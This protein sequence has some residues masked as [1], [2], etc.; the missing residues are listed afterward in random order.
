MLQA[1]TPNPYKCKEGTDQTTI[2][3]AAEVSGETPSTSSNDLSA[4]NAVN[5]NQIKGFIQ[6]ECLDTIGANKF[7]FSTVFGRA[8]RDADLKDQEIRK[9]VFDDLF[10]SRFNA[11]MQ[12]KITDLIEKFDRRVK[13]MCQDTIVSCAMTSCGDGNG[14]ACYAAAFHQGNRVMG[15]TNPSTLEQIKFGCEHI[16][17]SDIAC[18]Y[19]AAT[20]VPTTGAWSWE[21]NSI[22]DVLF[23]AADDVNAR[24]PDPTGAVAELNARL[25]RSYNQA[26]LDSMRLQ[27]QNVA[28]SCI[29]SM[30][31][32]DFSNCFRNRTDIMSSIG[33]MPGEFDGGRSNLVRGV[34]DRAI[35]IGLCMNTVRDNQMCAEHI[36]TE[37]ARIDAGRNTPSSTTWGGAA[38][39]REGWISAAT[40]A[41]DTRV[42]EEIQMQDEYG[43]PL[44]MADEGNEFD[45]Q[46]CGTE[47]YNIPYKVQSNLYSV[48]AAENQIFQKLVYDM[49]LEAQAI[50]NARITHQQNLCM[51][52]N[53]GGIMGNRDMAGAFMWVR[54][55]SQRIPSDYTIK[56]L[57]PNQFRASNDLYGSFCR[58]RV[59]LH[60][61]DQKIR[62]AILN[63]RAMRNYVTAYFA[64]G[65]AFTCGSWIPSSALEEITQ[66]II[67][68]KYDSQQRTRNWM[69]ALGAVT[70]AFGGGAGMNTLQKT[71]FGGLINTQGQLG[72]DCEAAVRSL[73]ACASMSTAGIAAMNSQVLVSQA[74]CAGIEVPR[75]AG[76]TDT[77]AAQGVIEQCRGLRD[78]L[79]LERRTGGDS[80]WSGTRGRTM[81]NLVGATVG[82][83]AGGVLAYQATKSVQMANAEGEAREW[84]DNV[85]RHIKCYIG[86]N[87]VG[88]FGMII[89]TELD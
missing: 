67:Q 2:L 86:S 83:V 74:S 1:C 62:D 15:V 36:R 78:R 88:D 22:F 52:A 12:T 56:G 43:R 28:Q 49:E 70:G 42:I 3:A 29:K 37:A 63:G 4:F 26:A 73:T 14:A 44:C 31:G 77:S 45:V 82:G 9:E 13:Q 30:C 46:P 11:S 41:Y 19:V 24:K 23:T 57:N 7:C 16:V 47:G 50:Y 6:T 20:F 27:C 76:V 60:S 89:S 38:N 69:T 33:G 21:S 17:N 40:V 85:G 80:W 61:D 54:L 81:M 32:S 18:K 84:L 48:R 59:S 34:L 87:E 8:A 39:V 66:T 79:E 10:G 64:A 65:D 35:V 68:E 51:Q 75:I 55:T 25:S 72:R 58:I 71:N 5:R 53:S